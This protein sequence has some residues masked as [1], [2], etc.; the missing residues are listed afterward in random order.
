MENHGFFHKHHSSETVLS[1]LSQY[2]KGLTTR[3]LGDEHDITQK[4]V[5]SW[6]K[7]Y[8]VLLF[9]FLC[10]LFQK[11]TKKLYV[12]ELFLRM[13]GKFYYVWDAICGDTRFLFIFLGFNRNNQCGERLLELCPLTE[14]V[15]TD[16]FP[17]YPRLIRK[18]YHGQARHIYCV[19]FE[20][21]K[22][23]NLIERFHNTLRRFLHPRRGFHSLK[24]GRSQL[25]GYWVF[26]NFIRTHTGIGCTPAE[27]AGLIEEWKVKTVKQRLE[28]LIQR[29]IIFWLKLFT[30]ITMVSI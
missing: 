26:Y 11:V 30:P 8:T 15:T 16:G 9:K 21:K 1:V 19:K 3:E 28:T 7:E 13:C 29:A 12:D 22:N 18:R 27:K 14:E 23:N 10:S 6:I 24:T 17:G 2:L 25:Q 4:T 20:D 5:L